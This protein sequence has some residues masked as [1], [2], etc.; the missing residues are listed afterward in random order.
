M[1]PSS[2]YLPVSTRDVDPSIPSR[3]KSQSKPSPMATTTLRVE[4]MTCGA[5]T[6]SV[7][8]AFKDVDSVS[9]VDVSLVLERAVFTHDPSQISAETIAEVIEARSFDATVISADV[10]DCWQDSTD[11]DAKSHTDSDFTV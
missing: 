3:S 9:N 2:S 1:A 4:G 8:A 5:C 10:L 11:D 7:E 6:S